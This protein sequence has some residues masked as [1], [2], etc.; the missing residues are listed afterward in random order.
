MFTVMMIFPMLE[1]I[2]RGLMYAKTVF[3]LI[4]REPAIQSP[5]E[6]RIDDINIKDGI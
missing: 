3:T 1:P 2:M 5:K 6:G 4:E